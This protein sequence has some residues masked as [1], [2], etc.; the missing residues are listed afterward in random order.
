MSFIDILR[1]VRGG[2]DLYFSP[3][4][5]GGNAYVNTHNT[6]HM[7]QDPD[8]GKYGSNPNALAEYNSNIDA[9]VGDTTDWN[10]ADFYKDFEI[11]GEDGKKHRLVIGYKYG[12]DGWG[13][14]D[15]S[16]AQLV[17]IYDKDVGT[18]P[19]HGRENLRNYLKN[20]FNTDTGKYYITDNGFYENG[21]V[22]DPENRH[23]Y[24]YDIASGSASDKNQQYGW[25]RNVSQ[26]DPNMMFPWSND[27]Y[28]RSRGPIVLPEGQTVPDNGILY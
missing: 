10:D 2:D 16:T 3:S 19:I 11:T 8:A 20:R 21:N 14:R 22:V 12:V 4:T 28:Y 17:N 23:Q 15:E 6:Y 9:Y 1:Q 24:V 13:D 7:S 27:V 25:G 18:D 26:Y 5:N